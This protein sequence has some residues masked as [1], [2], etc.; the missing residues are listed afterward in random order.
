MAPELELVSLRRISASLAAEA[1]HALGIPFDTRVLFFGFRAF[2]FL[3]FFTEVSCFT[4]AKEKRGPASL[5][6]L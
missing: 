5:A 1:L 6:G 4:T 3:R 2:L